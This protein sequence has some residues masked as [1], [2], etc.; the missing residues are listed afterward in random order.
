[1]SDEP[2]SWHK[3]LASLPGFLIK[4]TLVDNL[5]SPL[6]LS[7]W[8]DLLSFSLFPLSRFFLSF[9][10]APA[11][12]TI[13]QQQQRDS[14]M[15]GLLWGDFAFRLFACNARKVS[16]VSCDVVM[17]MMMII[18]LPPPPI[19]YAVLLEGFALYL[20]QSPRSHAVGVISRT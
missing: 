17:T 12:S 19:M 6:Y 9:S 18:C 13:H 11:H 5:V 10:P 15:F 4:I 3:R 8:L 2:W 16:S 7:P 1:M 20:L 14:S